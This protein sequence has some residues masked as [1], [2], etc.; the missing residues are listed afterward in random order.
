M[1]KGSMEI[2]TFMVLSKRLLDL[3]MERKRKGGW[4]TL[5]EFRHPIKLTPSLFNLQVIFYFKIFLVFTLQAQEACCFILT[6]LFIALHFVLNFFFALCVHHVVHHMWASIV[7][8]I[9]QYVC[10]S[11]CHC[12]ELGFRDLKA[13]SF[14]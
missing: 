2:F 9:V 10:S 12:F 11:C 3:E 14:L 7:V 5:R 1:A 13:L 4:S 6:S 8:F